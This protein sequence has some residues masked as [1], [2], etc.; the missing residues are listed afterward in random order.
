MEIQLGAPSGLA[1]SAPL[2]LWTMFL[3]GW[4][5]KHDSIQIAYQMGSTQA[6]DMDFP[7]AKSLPSPIRV[8]KWGMHSSGSII[9]V[10]QSIKKNCW[11]F[12]DNCWLSQAAHNAMGESRNVI[13]PC[14]PTLTCFKSTFPNFQKSKTHF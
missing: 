1:S 11:S 10:S 13:G 6:P 8:C 3:T 7:V 14:Q 5:S 12:K 9:S 2:T 4:L